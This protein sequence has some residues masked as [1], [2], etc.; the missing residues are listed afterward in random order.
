MNHTLT[1]IIFGSRSYPFPSNIISCLL[2]S[3]CN[4]ICQEGRD[5]VGFSLCLPGLFLWR[6]HVTQVVGW[7]KLLW[8]FWSHPTINLMCLTRRQ[9]SPFVCNITSNFLNFGFCSICLARD[10]ENWAQAESK[11]LLRFY[12]IS[13]LYG[14]WF[15]TFPFPQHLYIS[16]YKREARRIR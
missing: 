2:P 15:W 14:V 12:S 11:E 6:R 10:S 5:R 13:T 8:S 4:A 3:G 16:I 1:V 7:L 9:M